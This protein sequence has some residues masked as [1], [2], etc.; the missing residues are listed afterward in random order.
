MALLGETNGS[1]RLQRS[2]FKKSGSC[3]N[4]RKIIRGAIEAAV[5]TC[6]REE[7]IRRRPPHT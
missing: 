2:A 6:L 4:S 3:T 7:P 5:F 1:V